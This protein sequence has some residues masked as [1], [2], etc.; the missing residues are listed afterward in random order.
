MGKLGSLA[1][2]VS[3]S[4]GTALSTVESGVKSQ[5]QARNDEA[6]LRR[7]RALHLP[8]SQALLCDF[9]CTLVNGIVTADGYLFICNGLLCFQG[10]IEPAQS[11]SQQA[12]PLSLVVPWRAVASIQ[13]AVSLPPHEK[14]RP[15]ELRLL[16]AELAGKPDGLLIYATNGELHQFYN[17]SH[18]A[19][20]WYDQMW[21]YL[22]HA[23]RAAVGL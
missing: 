21:N 22:D 6:S 7:F 23:W 9:H 10:V 2:T 19:I 13:Q 3:S 11:L 1:V 18:Y 16:S 12:E 14:G 8:P 17:F 20:D 5:V 4:A 15:R